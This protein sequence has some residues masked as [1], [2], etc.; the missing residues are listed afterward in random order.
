[1]QTKQKKIERYQK[2]RNIY[3]YIYSFLIFL[4]CLFMCVSVWKQ[5]SS[6]C[7]GTLHEESENG[8]N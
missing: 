4:T 5:T 8:K 6:Q 7:R 1:M 3:I 2:D